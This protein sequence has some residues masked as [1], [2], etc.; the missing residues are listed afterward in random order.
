[1]F[2]ETIKYFVETNV[3]G[4]QFLFGMALLVIFLIFAFNSSIPIDLLLIFVLPF[5]ALL[6]ASGYLASYWIYICFL[7]LS[8]IYGKQFIEA[9]LGG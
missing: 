9:I 6:S 2:L 7:L 1:M 3:L 8:L 5:I 4:D